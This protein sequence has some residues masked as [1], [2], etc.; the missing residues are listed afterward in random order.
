[1]S[2]PLYFDMTE[3]WANARTG[4]PIWPPGHKGRAKGRIVIL[5]DE[6]FRYQRG[7]RD[8]RPIVDEPAVVLRFA[9]VVTATV[10][11]GRERVRIVR[12]LAS[13]PP[14]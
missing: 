3:L 2:T 1:M 9:R 7:W 10:Q 11:E 12:R 13:E 5:P 8:G 4:Q 14:L 6:T